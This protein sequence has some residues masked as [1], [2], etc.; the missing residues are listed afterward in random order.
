MISSNISMLWGVQRATWKNI[1]N[2]QFVIISFT[3]VLNYSFTILSYYSCSNLSIRI[4]IGYSL[5]S[6]DLV[7]RDDDLDQSRDYFWRRLVF[8]AYAAGL[9]NRRTGKIEWG[10]EIV[11]C[12]CLS[13]Y[14][15]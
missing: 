6:Y 13:N 12:I 11:A 1:Y 8:K 15:K 3:D 9:S 10:P 2:S 5:G 14:Q 7:L 4:V